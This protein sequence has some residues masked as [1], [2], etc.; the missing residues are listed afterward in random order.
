MGIKYLQTS[1]VQSFIY[2][3]FYHSGALVS[4]TSVLS[5]TY[6]NAG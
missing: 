6:H 5:A 3:F 2:G 4:V 1:C